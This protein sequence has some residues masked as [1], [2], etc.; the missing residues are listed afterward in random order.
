M[1]NLARQSINDLAASI[2]SKLILEFKA[3]G[4]QLTGSFINSIEFDVVIDD[5]KFQITYSYAM[6]GIYLR[7]GVAASRIPYSGR[8]KG[9]VSTG[10]TSKYIQAL[11]A[12]ARK[13]GMRNPKRAAF[14]IA[15]KH[16]REGMPTRASY[17]FSRN[18]RRTLFQESILD[19]ERANI[20]REV[21]AIFS[22]V[23]FAQLDE[24]VLMQD[25]AITI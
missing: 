21:N 24:V 15:A 13:R 5:G 2:K 25:M 10:R 23:I 4:H 19:S 16:K 14:A 12:Y 6:Y 1:L 17:R 9:R 22:R 20:E 8:G 18:G 11:I 7:K 3:Q